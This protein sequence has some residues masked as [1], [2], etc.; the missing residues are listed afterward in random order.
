MLRRFAPLILVA[1]AASGAPAAAVALG[2]CGSS[3]ET[4]D[5]AGA[6]DASVME[7]APPADAGT[8]ATDADDATDAGDATDAAD[9]SPAIDGGPA[10]PGP[11]ALGAT[12]GPSYLH[13]RVRADAATHLAVYLYAATT[14]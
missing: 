2:A 8:D 1:L 3:P 10:D 13:F 14:G 9:D 5:D 4:N 11:F 7:T 6:P 12:L